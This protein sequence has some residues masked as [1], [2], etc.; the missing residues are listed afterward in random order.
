M[1]NTFT[2]TGN[3]GAV[4][5]LRNVDVQAEGGGKEKRAVCDLRVYIDRRIPDGKGEF[6]DRGGF[7]L[8]ASLWGPR[9][10]A[11]AKLLSKGARVTVSGT[12][13]LHTWKDKES[14]E[15]RTD[16]RL[17]ADDVTLNLLRIDSVEFQPARGAS[18][19]GSENAG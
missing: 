13:Y 10:E 16:L 12:L 3:L 11:A 15:D 5:S 6:V 7:W 14:G 2:G 8:T 1:S 18:N 4:P 17:D 19:G 9:A